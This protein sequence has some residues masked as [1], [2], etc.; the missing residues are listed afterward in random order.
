M[1]S[2]SVQTVARDSVPKTSHLTVRLAQSA[3]EIDAAQALR[4]EVF[5][6]ENGARPTPKQAA[7]QRDFDALDE[8][9]DHLLV[10]D[11]SAAPG[12]D[13]VVGTYR[14]LRRSRLGTRLS[15]YSSSE[16]DLS[17]LLTFP[18]EALELGR[19]CVRAD[20]RNRP[21]LNLLWAGI[22]SYIHQHQ[23]TLMFGC[24]SLAG[25]DLSALSLQLAYLARHHLAPPELRARALPEHYVAMDRM[26]AHLI[27]PKLALATLPPLIKGYLRLGGFVG[28]GAVVDHSFNTT[29]VCIIVKTETVTDKYLRH[30]ERQ[31]VDLGAARAN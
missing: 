11:E 25:T 3:A 8:V 6:I 13:S 29:D 7:L 18:G 15:F 17:P 10:I 27:E 21:T 19:S 1:I 22:A 31:S 26:P 24:G 4:Y 12:P 23:V 30:Y 2:S 5:Y 28:D 16:F 20:Y 9:C 14:L